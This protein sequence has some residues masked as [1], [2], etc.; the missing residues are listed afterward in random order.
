MSI[1]SGK[2]LIILSFVLFVSTALRVYN[3][4][5][6]PNGLTVDEADMDYNAYSILKTGKDVYGRKL[7]LF[8]QSL[9][10][11][12]LSCDILPINFSSWN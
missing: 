10:D 11:Y 2:A 4:G 3:L 6:V 9:D 8:F 7:P 1:Y 12:K 5:E